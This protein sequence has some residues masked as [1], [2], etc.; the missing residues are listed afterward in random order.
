M[1]SKK[2]K[3]KKG[4]NLILDNRFSTADIKNGENKGLVHVTEAVGINFA[5][6][7]STDFVNLFGSSGFESD[8]YDIVKQ[9][10]F[11]KLKNLV[12]KP[13]Y[14]VGNIKIDIETTKSTIFCHLLGTIYKLY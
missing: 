10:A 1:K 5:R 2:K 11:N 7:I 3:V 6:D 13:N 14:C 9:K 12:N 8:L 4:D